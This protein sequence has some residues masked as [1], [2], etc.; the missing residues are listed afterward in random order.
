[1]ILLSNRLQNIDIIFTDQLQLSLLQGFR[2]AITFRRLHK[3]TVDIN[4]LHIHGG[5]RKFLD[6]LTHTIERRTLLNLTNTQKIFC[7]FLAYSTEVSAPQQQC[8]LHL[9]L[10]IWSRLRD[11]ICS[12]GAVT[13]HSCVVHGSNLD[14]QVRQ[15]GEALQIPHTA[16]KFRFIYSQKRN[17]AA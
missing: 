13:V 12:A 16:K 9:T 14:Y 1:M 8:L 6:T 3:K 2:E 11:L 5:N 10:F 7:P 17:C 15:R 4:K